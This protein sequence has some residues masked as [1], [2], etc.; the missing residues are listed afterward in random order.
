MRNTDRTLARALALTI[1]GTILM[2][3]GGEAP[4][5]RGVATA[6]AAAAE[7]DLV[8]Y[9]SPTCACCNAWIDHMREAGYSVAA[10]DLVEYEAMAGKKAELGVPGDLGSCHTAVIAG[11]TVEGHVP[12][13]VVARLLEERP[14]DIR[15]ISAPGMPIGSPGMEGANPQPYDV[16]AFR[17]DGSRVVY[18][19]I[20]PG[21]PA[22]DSR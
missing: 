16:I 10:V 18:E 7:A 19:S 21:R 12:A 9:K 4:A 11:Y 17:K 6:E 2:G 8:V 13:S 14:S 5:A 15:G 3:C 22:S 20:Y 1:A